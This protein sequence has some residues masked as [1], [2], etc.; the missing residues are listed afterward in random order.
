MKDN[1]KI[2]V[3]AFS[4]WEVFIALIVLGVFFACVVFP[5]LNQ[6][7]KAIFYM[8]QKKYEKAETTWQNQLKKEPFSYTYRMNLALN[9]LL[10][11]QGEKALHEYKMARDFLNP[12][13]LENSLTQPAFTT[14]KEDSKLENSN[15]S[16]I[17]P[18]TPPA[19]D[20]KFYSFFNSAIATNTLQKPL[21]QV[22]N[23]YQQALKFRPRSLEVKTNIELLIKNQSP[24]KNKNS[25]K[26]S[27]KNSSNNKNSNSGSGFSEM[28]NSEKNQDEKSTQNQKEQKENSKKQDNN[29]SQ[30]NDQEQEKQNPSKSENDNSQNGQPQNNGQ[31]QDD[32][33][34]NKPQENQQDNG[35]PQQQPNS[36]SNNDSAQGPDTEDKNFSSFTG[37]NRSQ[38]PQ[39]TLNQKQVDTILKAILEQEK[40]I[41][42]R[43]Q[44]DPR[45]SSTQREKD[46]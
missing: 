23:F 35:Q 43:R 26:N 11:N 21:N 19:L 39:N 12:T 41:R 37:N 40:A 1:A 28:Q 14:Y 36:S 38:Q 27:D 32:N 8:K 9:Y 45:S 4:F 22:L 44:K 16:S 13:G 2:Q 15:K 42:Q 6:N 7:N 24:S 3:W 33:Q 25:D 34:D 10:N 18:T 20:S 31:P 29:Q 17:N 5:F 30:K 46:W